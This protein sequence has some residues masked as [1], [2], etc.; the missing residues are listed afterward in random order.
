MTA[1]SPHVEIYYDERGWFRWRFRASNG[2]VLS[3]SS[4]G[5]VEPKGLVRG[6]ELSH[7]GYEMLDGQY[8]LTGYGGWYLCPRDWDTNKQPVIRVRVP[9]GTVK[10]W[11]ARRKR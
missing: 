3:Q 6:L 1:K 7:P 10:L 9:D 8:G 11:R 5:Y 2:K 4:E